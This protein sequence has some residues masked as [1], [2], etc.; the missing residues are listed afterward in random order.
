[1]Q[2]FLILIVSSGVGGWTYAQL[3]KRSGVGNEKNAAIGATVAFVV[4]FV[5]VFSIVKMTLKSN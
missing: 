2:A 5:L 1:M 3:L 4:A